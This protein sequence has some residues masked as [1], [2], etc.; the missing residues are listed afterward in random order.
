[1]LYKCCVLTGIIAVR[2]RT[3]RMVGYL[4]GCFSDRGV[5]G[6][7]AG[8]GIGRGRLPQTLGFHILIACDR[9]LSI[10]NVLISATELLRIKTIYWHLYINYK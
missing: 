9:L 7:V 6:R 4:W 8:G 3:A 10:V 5:K 1:M 2:L